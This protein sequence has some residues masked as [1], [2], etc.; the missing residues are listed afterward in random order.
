MLR[1]LRPRLASLLLVVPG[2]ASVAA[3]AHPP[4]A[5]PLPARH[6]ADTRFAAVEHDYVTYVLRQ[7]PVVATYLGGAGFDPQLENVDGTL[8]DYSPAA[9][10]QEDTRLAEFRARFAALAPASLSARRRIDRNDIGKR[11]SNVDADT[12][13][14]HR[15]QSATSTCVSITSVTASP[16]A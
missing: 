5:Q 7:F 2:V 13:A 6:V 4:S 1:T 9:L 8:R 3:S 16:R 11:P 12:D 15:Y 10:Q 14:L